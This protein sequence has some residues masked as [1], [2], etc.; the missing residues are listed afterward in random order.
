MQNNIFVDF[1]FHFSD[2]ITS[3]LT[4]TEVHYLVFLKTYTA[5]NHFLALA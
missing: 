2:W 1:L 5:H 3:L 4:M